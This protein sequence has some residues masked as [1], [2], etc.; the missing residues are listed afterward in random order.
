M[1]KRTVSC[2]DA[3]RHYDEDVQQRASPPDPSAAECPTF[4]ACFTIVRTVLL[5]APLVFQTQLSNECS[6][7]LEAVRPVEECD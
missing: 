6:R 5:V 4:E 3:P 1:G 7:D 2:A